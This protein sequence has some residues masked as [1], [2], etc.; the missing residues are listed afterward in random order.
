MLF[1]RRK[2]RREEYS[3]QMKGAKRRNPG[4]WRINTISNVII[5]A[6]HLGMMAASGESK[7]SVAYVMMR[8][9]REVNIYT[10]KESYISVLCS[11]QISVLST[12]E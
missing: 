12:G 2:A 10:Q 4:L 6:R 5:S 3:Y 1:Y 8:H 7:S 9:F 11:N